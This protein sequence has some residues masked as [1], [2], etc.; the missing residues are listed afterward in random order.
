MPPSLSPDSRSESATLSSGVSARVHEIEH[1]IEQTL[2]QTLETAERSI[3]QRLGLRALRTVRLTLRI[4][5]WLL[6]ALFFAVGAL[7][8]VSRYWLLPDIDRQR[9][10]IEAF[11]SDLLSTPVSVGRIEASWRGLNP[12][13]ALN[14]VRVGASDGRELS[15][16]RVE[17][18]LSWSSLTAWQPRFSR[19]RILA[20]ELD[21]ALLAEGKLSV[22]SFV[23]DPA[24]RSEENR[25]LDWLLAQGEIT[26]SDARVRLRDERNATPR[27]LRFQDMDL[28]LV[29]GWG[30]HRFGI[31]AAPPSSLAA[32][33]EVRGQM[34]HSP[35]ERVTDFSLWSGEVFAQF[36]YVDLAQLNQWLGLPIEAERAHGA[37]RG[38]V[39]FDRTELI[40]VVADLALKDVDVRLA[41]DLESMKLESLQGRL[42]ERSWGNSM[43]GGE[44][45]GAAG[46]TFRT[47]T[48]EVFAPLDL[49]VRLTRARAENQERTEVKASRI[50]LAG[51]S[52]L[53]SH[54][55]LAGTLKELVSRQAVKGRL[56]NL[57]LSWD[58]PRPQIETLALKMQ[59]ADLANAPAASASASTA[60]RDA[61]AA[62]MLPQFENLS[63][64]IEL[65]RGAGRLQLAS[66]N[67]ALI[68]PGVFAEPRL[69]F[70]QLNAA[71]HWK[72]TPQLDVSVDSLS[73]SNQDLELAASGT[74][75][76]KKDSNYAD[77]SGRI[78]RLDLASAYRYVPLAAGPGT[79]GWLQYALLSG[80]G[81]DGSF[82]VRG[83]LD[84][85]PFVRAAD[86]EFRA[87]IKV[88]DA[89]LDVAPAAND[90]GTRRPGKHWPTL[91]ELNADVVFE[92]NSM[93]VTAERGRLQG[94]RIERATARIPDLNHSPTLDVQGQVSGPLLEMLNYVNSSPVADWLGG[95]TRGVDARGPARLDLQ[96]GIPLSIQH[97]SAKVSGA[98]QLSGNDLLLAGLPPLARLNGTLNFTERGPR[99]SNVS[100]GFLGGTA[101]FD[102]QV[103]ADGASVLTVGGTFTPAGL[104][105]L[106][107]S[108]IVERVLDR[109]QGSARYSGTFT[110]Q[111]GST[112]LLAES[113]LV[114][115]AIDGIAPLRKSASETWPL[116]IERQ[117]RGSDQ[118]DLS[119][120]AGK[121]LAM[122]LERRR[123]QG[124]WRTG[125]GVIAINE[126]ANLPVSGVLLNIAM[127]RLDVDAWS[128]WL[129]SSGPNELQTNARSAASDGPQLDYV[130]LRTAELIVQRRSIRN[131][132]LGA[133]R[134][135]DGGFDANLVSDGIIGYIGWRPSAPGSPDVG[136]LGRISAKLSK[137]IIPGAIKEEVVDVL[138]APTRQIPS[139]DVSAE[140]FELG[141]SKLGRLD[142]VAQNFGTA[143]NAV[144]RLRRLDIVNPD[145]KLAASGEWAPAG[146]NT[147]RMQLKFTI[148][149]SDVG[150]TL[151]RLGYAQTMARGQGQIGGD[152]DWLGSPLDIDY[153]SLSGKLQLRVDNGRFLKVETGSAARLLGLL[154][155]QSLSR[156]LTDN[157]RD[158]FGEGFAFSSI[159]ADATITR[160]VLATQNFRMAG[161]S[162][163]VLM[164]GSLDLRNE[165]QDLH[166]VVLPE[167]DASTAA[168]ALTVVN[169]VIGLGAFLAQTVLRDPLSRALAL[170]YDITGS[171]T[172]PVIK[173]RSRIAPTPETS[174]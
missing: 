4:I 47:A 169:P 6:L 151:A 80:R 64:T 1:T 14:D 167:V 164:S 3:V 66:R 19:L 76:R 30:S 12:Q 107:D 140:S 62:M 171:W 86:G 165:T 106:V 173:R 149:A 148:D 44:E 31:N 8:L 139:V 49:S 65:N 73:A 141:D 121:L 116:R 72:T 134:V 102:G 160:G 79:L 52:T 152:V 158:T 20:P 143:S 16:P 100:A 11:A 137:L 130:A 105:R 147:R 156:V 93:T 22:A 172:D 136:G 78:T 135:A 174:K 23:I 166:L 110:V 104:R 144:W 25:G 61:T 34:R 28:S 91:S 123:E 35:F 7:I 71:V 33:F 63:G 83:A 82:R 10:R 87:A 118:E 89:T 58:G 120:N 45:Y 94:A 40:K 146:P 108:T 50:D 115:L 122:R 53:A 39:S 163:A 41:R 68:F 157:T 113:D 117:T 170:E 101:R 17:A 168:L 111:S 48:G 13:F 145:M 18:I 42:S 98:L 132:T 127:P 37:L 159:R 125:R 153:P 84:Q 59:F 150:G 29:R 131:V 114:G 54:V 161:A 9:P 24:A 74:W 85:F 154:S 109:S 38:W 138:R 5:A 155:L 21:I 119:L 2:A 51:L 88:R 124:E 133:S 129:G 126:P 32:P 95:F 97:G 103:R 55:P 90:D 36:D 43:M 75:Q 70:N 112:S 27:E 99:F 57:D 67:V 46:L 81:T 15:L 96:L 60:D 26:I 128:N 162:A 92:R 69:N 77:L 142:L 56:S